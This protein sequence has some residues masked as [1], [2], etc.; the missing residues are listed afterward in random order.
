MDKAASRGAAFFC[1]YLKKLLQIMWVITM[2]I[3]IFG[4]RIQTSLIWKLGLYG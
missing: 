2:N 4:D 1:I 3:R